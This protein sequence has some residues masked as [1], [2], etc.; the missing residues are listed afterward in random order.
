MNTAPASAS[1]ARA[2]LDGN[3]QALESNE[4]SSRS[5]GS[6]H[7]RPGGDTMNHESSRPA[8][9]A[10]VISNNWTGGAVDEGDN[11]N[12]KISVN[13]KCAY[14]NGDVYEGEFKDG[15]I[16]GK[17]KYTFASGAV[18]EGEFKDD[19]RNGN[20]K[21]TSASGE[22][23][24][25]EWKDGKIHGNG[26]NTYADGDVY[27]GEYKDGQR[28]GNG[29]NTYANGDVYEGE[30]KDGE[31]KGNGKRTAVQ[32]IFNTLF[33]SQDWEGALLLESQLT[34]ALLLESQL[35]EAVENSHPSAACIICYQL[36]FAHTEL[37]REGS[38]EQAII[39][40]MKAIELAKKGTDDST[41]LFTSVYGL[42]K[43]YG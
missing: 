15:E 25:G 8:K 5:N 29:K 21:N 34:E 40:Y 41:T 26:K 39:H 2:T 31:R 27:E 4:S 7:P 1:A 17:G 35:T 12:G 9:K 43:C 24:E 10:E 18:C 32:Q 28:Y 19:Q 14:A 23:Y 13:V 11:T 16:N 30:W 6:V 38:M 42:A 37:A 33:Q 36:G 22:V 3:G 20:G